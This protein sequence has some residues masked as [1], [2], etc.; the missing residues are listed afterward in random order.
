MLSIQQ[1]LDALAEDFEALGDWEAQL[2]H[3][4]DMGRTLSPFPLHEQTEANKVRGCA[5]QLWM[6]SEKSADGRLYFRADADAL[7]SKG[8]AAVVIH[9]VSGH[10]PAEILA[11]DLRQ[12]FEKL[13]LP[14][15]SMSRAS[16]L[17]SMAARIRR[18]AEQNLV[19]GGALRL[20]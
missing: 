20:G 1:K 14:R 9:L 2:E 13:G 3:V 8:L 10:Y 17:A 16:G 15:L 12:A 18:E 11:F 7:I 19:P 6:I 4:M 5:S